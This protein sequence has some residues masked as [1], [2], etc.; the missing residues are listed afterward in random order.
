MTRFPSALV[1]LL[2]ASTSLRAAPIPPTPPEA[3]PKGATARL[4][5]TAFR[6]DQTHGLW[7]SADGANLYAWSHGGTVIGWDARTGKR[8]DRGPFPFGQKYTG[9]EPIVAGDRIIRFEEFYS[10]VDGRFVG[11]TATITGSDG[12]VLS[13]IDCS[14][15]SFIHVSARLLPMFSVCRDGSRAAVILDEA[16]RAVCV[17][18][19][20]TGKELF[21]TKLGPDPNPGALLAPDGNTLYLHEAGKDVRRIALPDGK[22]LA[23]LA[24]AADSLRVLR[25]SPDEKIAI[26]HS[27]TTEPDGA[28]NR[29]SHWQNYLVVHDLGT[30]KVRG[31]L[32]LAGQPDSRGFVG[33]D[34]VVVTSSGFG[35]NGRLTDV[36]SRWNLK[37]LQKEWQIAGRGTVL[38][39][40]DG[41][42]F[43]MRCV[44]G[45]R[46]H[47][48]AT[49]KRRDT[50]AVHADPVDWIG[51]STDGA[52]VTTQ[53]YSEVMT[54]TRS[55]ERKSAAEP[56]EL[57]NGW[58]YANRTNSPRV[59]VRFSTNGLTRELV[60]WDI[61]KS[62]V[63]WRMPLKDDLSERILSLDGRRAVGMTR[64]EKTGDWTVR[65]YDGPAGKVTGR[66][67]LKGDPS[68]GP[69]E[70]PGMAL[71]GDGKTLFVSD[72][73]GV[74]GVDT[75]TGKEKVRVNTG[76]IVLSWHATATL[77]VTAD[78]AR[79][80]VVQPD[81]DDRFSTLR[82]FDVKSGK[83]LSAHPLGRVSYAAVKFDATGSRV[84]AWYIGKHVFV[85]DAAGD[86]RLRLES[87]DS[88]PTCAEFHPDGRALAV[89]YRDGTALV[90]D[91]S[92]K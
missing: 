25:I 2:C 74:S 82:V 72:E 35:S 84:A 34:A 20:T 51:F 26:T 55:G 76:E 23:P 52:T 48:A 73:K 58:T 11:R 91:L 31:K 80:A 62:A 63:A 69:H 12:K 38:L 59:W 18:E 64:I 83:Q 75:E 77:A 71:T 37:T 22:E 27:W 45:I 87:P 40:P 28:G 60:G 41:K 16:A 65:V 88:A 39:A 81:S 13:R 50:V 89:G 47:D 68:A 3:L 19:L 15:R 49:G 36:F 17:F 42:T 14:R 92:A 32:E 21:R 56:P 43:A 66:W 78:G 57:R 79:L 24:T 1:L 5:S 90:W 8:L 33:S 67:V 85:C 53:S 9:W 70:G 4:G 10:D 86:T 44:A 46:I 30:G 54:W 6:C 29:T 61:D 7:Y